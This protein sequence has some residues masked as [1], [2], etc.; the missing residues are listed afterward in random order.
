MLFPKGMDLADLCGIGFSMAK[1]RALTTYFPTAL[2]F[3]SERKQLEQTVNEKIYSRKSMV[4][5]II[6]KLAYNNE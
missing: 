5:T 2:V 1:G 3:L 4:R 6:K